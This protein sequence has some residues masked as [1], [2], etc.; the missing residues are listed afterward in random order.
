MKTIIFICGLYNIAF[1][2]FHFG[3]WKMFKWNKDLEKLSF[4]NK[5]IMQILNIQICYYFVL[6]AAICFA[7]PSE[8]LT[9]KFGN[10][11]LIGTSIFW[12]IR[13]V[14]QFIFLR[15]NN[16]KIHILT[17]IFLIGTIL[18]ALPIFLRE[19]IGNV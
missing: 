5:G 2:L 12:L 19:F 8:L 16:Y 11:F 6:T 18:F 4:A 13:T 3:F 17:F 10:W 1:A 7:F 9:T 15:A 14:Q